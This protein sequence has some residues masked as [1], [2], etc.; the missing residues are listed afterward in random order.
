MRSLEDPPRLK[1]SASYCHDRFC[2]PCQRSRSLVIAQN[3][4][5]LIQHKQVRMVTLTIATDLLPLADALT[6]LYNSFQQL[7]RTPLW[8]ST[9]W[10]GCAILEVK[11]SATLPRWHPHLHVLTEGKYLS[12]GHLT[13]VWYSITGTSHIVDIRMVKSPDHAASYVTK[14]LTKPTALRYTN[15]DDL[16]DETIVAL[17]GRRS[18][19]PFGT[20][21]GLR[22]TRPIPDGD[23][24]PVLPLADLIRRAAGGSPPDIALLNALQEHRQCPI[25]PDNLTRGPPASKSLTPRSAPYAVSASI[26]TPG[27][28]SATG[29]YADSA[30][31]TTPTMHN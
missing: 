29:L 2:S 27:P 1:I 14:Y 15:H 16:L 26:T 20:W 4:K 17:K 13:Q 22:L 10:G 23:W 31:S 9:V 24:I 30:L 18:V 12:Q 7:R 21:Y 8:K 5:D 19:M 25:A 11:R 6:M 28:L 3:L